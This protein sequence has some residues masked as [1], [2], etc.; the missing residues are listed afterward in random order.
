MR[1]EREPWLT[2]VRLAFI[3]SVSV[4]YLATFSSR[5]IPFRI[6]PSPFPL[7]KRSTPLS[8]IY[9]PVTMCKHVGPQSPHEEKRAMAM[10]RVCVC[11]GVGWGKEIVKKHFCTIEP[12]CEKNNLHTER[13]W[14]KWMGKQKNKIAE[15]WLRKKS[16]QKLFFYSTFH[17]HKFKLTIP[18]T[19]S[20]QS[21][22]KYCYF[23]S[24]STFWTLHKFDLFS[25]F[26]KTHSPLSCS[27]VQLF[28]AGPIMWRQKRFKSKYWKN[29]KYWINRYIQTTTNQCSPKKTSGK[30]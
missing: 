1:V 30:S 26:Y 18:T 9:V 11:S 7:R 4:S 10:A 23:K 24:T 8:Y 16:V 17:P 29:V 20:P 3:C 28:G 22:N 2:R 13:L 5:V 15:D 25:L 19:K 14:R 6:L 27:S 12:G 21:L